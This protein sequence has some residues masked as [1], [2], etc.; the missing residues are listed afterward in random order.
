MTKIVSLRL[1]RPLRTLRLGQ[2]V[3]ILQCP[4]EEEADVGNRNEEIE[5]EV[6]PW[7]GLQ[8]YIEKPNSRHDLFGSVL[9]YG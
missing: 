3:T 8:L 5:E 6:G 2:M 1:L 7:T 9:V 4:S